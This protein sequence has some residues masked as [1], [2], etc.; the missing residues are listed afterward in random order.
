MNDI[1]EMK[2]LWDSMNHKLSQF[3]KENQ[4]L[5]EKVKKNNMKSSQEKLIDKYR[6]FIIV[7]C[8]MIIVI[9]LTLSSNPE[10]NE[11]YRWITIIYWVAFFLIEIAF[12]LYL[13][14]KVKE[15]DI[16]NQPVNEIA[17]R[18]YANWRLHK[19]GILFGMPLAVGAVV[20]YALCMNAN[21]FVILGMCVGGIVGLI[22]GLFHLRKFSQ[23][24]RSMQPDND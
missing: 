22:I 12:D 7:E 10:V 3:E 5:A 2:K 13:L 24:Y 23:Y 1:E 14:R 4:I 15:I 16:Y 9:S 8:L 20:L 11:H 19:A 6:K 18:A 21:Y 17:C